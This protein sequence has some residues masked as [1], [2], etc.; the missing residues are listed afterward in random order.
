MK[1]ELHP[2]EAAW[3]EARKLSLGGSD[4]ASRL[5]FKG[6]C[7]YWLRK[8]PAAAEKFACSRFHVLQYEPQQAETDAHDQQS[9]GSHQGR[10][11]KRYLVEEDIAE[12]Q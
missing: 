7:Y 8:N 5:L 2:D 9:N 6:D 11:I 3:L 1:I 10:A 4:Q 12:V